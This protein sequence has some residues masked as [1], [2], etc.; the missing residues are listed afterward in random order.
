MHPVL[1]RLNIPGFGPLAIY[2]YGVMLGLSLVVG[3]YLTLGLA[4]RDGLPKDKMAN[5][6]VVTAISA[7][8]AS[9]LLY[10][11]TN[12]DEF[13]GNWAEV[14]SF[15]SGGLVAYGGFLGG[16]A[17]S[18]LYLKRH[19]L[20]LLPWADVAVPSLASGLM[21]TRIGCY[22]F[23]C[24]FG[25]P[26]AEGA[27]GFL[28]KLGTFPHWVKGT[29]EGGSG[30]PAFV[31]HVKTRGLA[32]D[33]AASLP[34][35]PTQLYE[36]L[37]GLAL[38]VLL[39]SVRRRQK[40][41]GQIFFIFAFAYGAARFGL[42][43]VR[44]DLERGAIPPALPEHVLLS[45]SLALFAVAYSLGIAPAIRNGALR[46]VTQ[47]ASVV[48]AVMAY[49][50]YAPTEFAAQYMMKLSTSQAIGLGSGVAA[51]FAYGVFHRAA[52]Q[53]PASAMALDLPP[54]PDAD[55]E[56]EA[57][58]K[59][60][61]TEAEAERADAG[62]AEEDADA[63]TRKPSTPPAA[64]DL[65]RGETEGDVAEA[66]VAALVKKKKKKTKKNRAAATEEKPPPAG[67]DPD[68]PA[69]DG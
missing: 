36:S 29:I 21:I 23:G 3:W 28:Q 40:F 41:R 67:D 45:G 39:L 4:E 37:V 38:L 60:D 63:G 11:L 44:D 34:V 58:E 15:R 13:S 7:V 26:L 59:A 6:Y 14:V 68:K 18:Y 42:E 17:G 19:R 10:V 48:P 31:H 65:D 53:H 62:T 24:D 35:H 61:M 64:P 49:V 27:P 5:N 57:A 52:L 1:F 9:R 55:R 16:L 47:V 32:P 33:A 2:A 30:A 12:L 20:P 46:V 54:D 51:A 66:P 22:M 50:A 69:D 25:R 56:E 8:V 43:L